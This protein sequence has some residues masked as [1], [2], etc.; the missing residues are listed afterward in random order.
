MPSPS[1]SRDN[2]HNENSPLPP[3]GVQRSMYRPLRRSLHRRSASQGSDGVP[4]LA[5]RILNRIRRARSSDAPGSVQGDAASGPASAIAAAATSVDA[6]DERMA[7]TSLLLSAPDATESSPEHTN[8]TEPEP[9]GSSSEPRNAVAG[10]SSEPPRDTEVGSTAGACATNTDTAEQSTLARRTAA[11]RARRFNP[12]SRG[13]QTSPSPGPSSRP[14]TRLPSVYGNSHPDI[15]MRWDP[16]WGIRPSMD[17]SGLH[18]DPYPERPSHSPPP[19]PGSPLS[20]SALFEMFASAQ[21]DDGLYSVPVAGPSRPAER[22]LPE[23]PDTLGFD[24]N[25]DLSHMREFVHR[26]MTS[27]ANGRRAVMNYLMEDEGIVGLSAPVGEP[28]LHRIPTAEWRRDPDWEGGVVRDDRPKRTESM[29]DDGADSDAS[30]FEYE[31]EE[32]SDPGIAT[33][34][35]ARHSSL[36]ADSAAPDT[37]SVAESSASTSPLPRIVVTPPPSSAPLPAVDEAVCAVEQDG[38]S[39]LAADAS[40]PELDRSMTS[41]P[42]SPGPATP[43]PG[44]RRRPADVRTLRARPSR[45]SVSGRKRA[46]EDGADERCADLGERRTKKRRDSS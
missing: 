45:S 12:I 16:S 10:P 19:Y 11:R 20:G 34:D 42:S 3:R 17:G 39:A 7:I 28:V 21:D 5:T 44:S 30:V 26:L 37:Q 31:S 15:W 4:S 22:T 32:E 40:P 33:G 6:T 8:P 29:M 35:G 24:A 1:S 46:R 13:M 38:L 2:S 23:Q 25:A 18:G 9:S 41:P 43:P 27:T 14:I 36:L